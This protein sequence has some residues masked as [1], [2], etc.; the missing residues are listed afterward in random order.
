MPATVTGA[1]P[2]HAPRTEWRCTREIGIALHTTWG[3]LNEWTQTGYALLSER[4]HHP[5]L[6]ELLGRFMRQEGRTSTAT[7]HKP[8]HDSRQITAPDGSRKQRWRTCGA[9]SARA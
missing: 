7:R 9:P 6:S 8:E 5:V 4:A 1:R 3:A 2:R